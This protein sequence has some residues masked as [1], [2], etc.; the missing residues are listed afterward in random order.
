[1]SETRRKTSEELREE[2][3][4]VLDNYA[5]NSLTL[6]YQHGGPGW[7]EEHI[8]E[9]CE[10]R[11]RQRNPDLLKTM[12]VATRLKLTSEEC[13]DISHDELCKRYKAWPKNYNE[14]CGQ[15][16]SFIPH[17]SILGHLVRPIFVEM[18]EDLKKSTDAIDALEYSKTTL[19]E[20]AKLADPLVQ[21]V[22]RI[23]SVLWAAHLEELN[24]LKKMDE[25]HQARMERINDPAYQKAWKNFIQSVMG[26][27]PRDGENNEE[28][29]RKRN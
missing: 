28:N 14:F 23:R 4:D 11:L 20:L 5:M 10:L 21:F 24:R 29:D 9:F 26:F 25:E 3:K 17:F 18:W 12:P 27:E 19:D 15:D 7:R 1:M 8:K 13:L 2:Y 16:D 6:D 22:C